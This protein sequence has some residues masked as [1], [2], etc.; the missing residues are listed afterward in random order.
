M[1]QTFISLKDIEDQT[2][3]MCRDAIIRDPLEF[4]FVRHQTEELSLL[5][6]S[7]NACMLS[8]VHDQ[9]DKIVLHAIH[10][11]Q[12]GCYAVMSR[13]RNMNDV[14]FQSLYETYGNEVRNYMEFVDGDYFDSLL[15][16]AF[17][18][19]KIDKNREGVHFTVISQHITSGDARKALPKPES[20]MDGKYWW[21]TEYKVIGT[22]ETLSIPGLFTE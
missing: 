13:I 4:R 12:Y 17:Y 1:S 2:F 20:N 14:I 19:V 18:I 6:V 7:H 8:D 5:A 22:N 16:C 15:N 9:T 10:N 3:E 21:S 11:N